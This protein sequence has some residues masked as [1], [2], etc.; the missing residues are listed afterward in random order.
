[1]LMFTLS[2]P[3]SAITHIGKKLAKKFEYL[4]VKTAADLLNYYPF[5]YDD[6]RA[7]VPIKNLQ[8]A[9]RVTVKARVVSINSRRNFK[10][11]RSI[12]EGLIGDD[13]GAMRLVWF[14]QPF[15]AKILKPGAEYYFAG[16]VKTDMLGP[17]FMN[18]VFEAVKSSG[19]A[20]HTARLVPMY[21][22]TR[23][24][25]Q[26][27]IRFLIS[28]IAP[29]ATT[30]P[31]WLP[32]DILKKYNLIKFSAALGAIHFPD[33]ETKLKTSIE[34]LKFDELFLIQLRAELARRE[35][36]IVAAPPLKFHAPEIKNF[37]A[38]LP[39]QLTSA[40]KIV[41]WEIL[42]DIEKPSPMNRLLSGDV[43]SGKT[44]VAA[45]SAYNA[46][47]NGWQVAVMAPTE[48]LAVQHY[49][50]LQSL[51]GAA[52]TVGLL[53]NS[54]FAQSD[55][56][57]NFKSPAKSRAALRAKINSGELNVIVGTHSLLSEGVN[58]KK[59]G[60]VIVD[61]QHR[62]GVAQRRVIKQKGQG[63]HFLSMTATPI[64]RSLA[65]VMYGDLDISTIN[66]LP[67][68]RKKILT[69]L[70][71]P[72]K[73]AAA[74][75][76]IREQIKKGR[77][78]FVVCPLIEEGAEENFA[79][80]AKSINLFAPMVSAN[81]T[82]ALDKR[83]VLSEF[84]RLSEK[85][86]PDLKI[87][88]LHGKMA[89]KDKQA[90][91]TKFKSGSIDILVATSVVEVGVDIPNASVMMIEGADRF[92]LA[93]LHQFRGRVG[94][95]NHQSYC[96]LFTSSDNN[97]SLERLKFFETH[98]DGFALA[99]KDLEIRGPG[100]VY[101][102]EQSGASALKIAKLTDKILIKQA[103][104]AACQ[105]AGDKILLPTIK[106]RLQKWESE[107]HLE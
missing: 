46:F 52:V 70:V 7:V 90:V 18:P 82:P 2:T 3:I 41:A 17:E 28:Q 30:I 33:D 100:E 48:I 32:D 61:E 75:N 91:M 78:A 72:S 25:S 29:L 84:K 62:F 14:N 12:T 106:Q 45:L 86:F 96:L 74:Y 102:T 68:G 38:S 73:R 64:P 63:A 16:T 67:P 94:R 15:I 36:A 27:Q 101:G 71:E 53:T 76:F 85:V 19:V 97:K 6:L 35:Q 83:S 60:L 1:M 57:L 49:N 34:R 104:E 24:L 44:V 80:S 5:R 51:F 95:S 39:F 77:Q 31:D 21:H 65:L 69:R 58:F 43:G 50:S 89:G 55:K 107:V 105:I 40:Q 47:L 56:R 13:S 10:T 22:L 103:R 4:G 54:E 98:N 87:A 59:L 26:K 99:E 9:T 79:A 11:R 81:V 8:E 66:E 93:Q 92:G 42:Q 23:G 88:W 20:T 37:V